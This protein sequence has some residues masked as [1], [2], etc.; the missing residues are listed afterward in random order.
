[1]SREAFDYAI[2]ALTRTDTVGFGNWAYHRRE[3][4]S[5]LERARAEY[6]ATLNRAKTKGVVLACMAMSTATLAFTVVVIFIQRGGL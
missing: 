1:M 4:L 3:A 2:D 5:R 6:E